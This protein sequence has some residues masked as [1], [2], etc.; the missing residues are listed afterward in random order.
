[1]PK[2]FPLERR[3]DVRRE[4]ERERR[5]PRCR[6]RLEGARDLLDLRGEVCC[7]RRRSR[8]G[9]VPGPR[10]GQYVFDQVREAVRLAID[11]VERPLALRLGGEAAEAQRLEE[12]T[13]LGERRAQLVRDARDEVGAQTRQLLLAAELDDRNHGE[14]RRDEEHAEEER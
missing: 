8:R 9:R 4:L 3:H 13:D 2:R 7:L 14:R 12:Q 6:E 1:M 10:E 11:V 5:T